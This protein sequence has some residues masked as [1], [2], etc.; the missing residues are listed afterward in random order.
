MKR[1][2]IVYI[3]PPSELLPRERASQYGIS[4]L[5]DKELFALLLGSGNK[6]CGVRDL[7]QRFEISVRSTKYQ[8][9]RKARCMP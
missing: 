8:S 2:T 7:A 4:A 6:Q 9:T 5:T 1:K 3:H